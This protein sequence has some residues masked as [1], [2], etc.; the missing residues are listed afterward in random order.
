VKMWLSLE[1]Q[2]A[3]CDELVVTY[4]QVRSVGRFF[5]GG[6]FTDPDPKLT[7]DCW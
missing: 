4:K 7:L 6:L 5:P 1:Q 2:P 3:S